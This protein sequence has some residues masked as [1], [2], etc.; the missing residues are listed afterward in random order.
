MMSWYSI[1]G[2]LSLTQRGAV[3]KQEAMRIIEEYSKRRAETFESGEDSLAA[4]LFGFQKSETEFVE[5]CFSSTD[6]SSF[7]YEIS[8]PRK[9]LFMSFPMVT[10]AEKSF[11]RV[12][13]VKTAVS[14]FYDMDS[15]SF[16]SL[17]D[18]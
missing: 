9:I 2:N 1:D 13:D 5:I 3:T 15:A 14:S 4:T 12:E 8:I 18:A 10:R 11:R 16:L 17:L 6:E 7:T